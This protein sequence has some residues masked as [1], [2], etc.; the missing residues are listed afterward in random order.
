MENSRLIGLAK[1][2]IVTINN[3]QKEKKSNNPIEEEK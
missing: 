2:L 1:Y 3:Q